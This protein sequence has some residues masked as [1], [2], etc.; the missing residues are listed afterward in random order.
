MFA[1]SNTPSIVETP[2]LIH[3]LNLTLNL[4]PS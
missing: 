4:S 1:L 3:I 2:T